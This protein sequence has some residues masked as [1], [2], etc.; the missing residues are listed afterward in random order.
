MEMTTR[1][2][3]VYHHLPHYRRAIFQEL[4]NDATLEVE[5]VAANQ[6]RDGSIPTIPTNELGSFH[7]VTNHWVGRFMWQSGLLGLLIRRRPDVVI[8]LGDASY[9]TTWLGSLLG[10]ALGSR[11]LFWTIGWHK[12]EAGVR[13]IVRILFYRLAHQLLL[14]GNVAR[15]IGLEMGYPATR[16][17]V[18]YNSSSAPSPLLAT[19]PESLDEFA[20]KLPSGDRPVA[21]AVIRLNRVKRLDMLVQAAS[22]LRSRGTDVD[23]L[24]VGEGPELAKLT[25]QARSL[26]VRLYTPG[27]AYGDAALARV[28][29]VTDVTVV[30]SV[31]GLTVLQSLRYGRPV[32]THDNIYDQAPESE[33]IT[34]GRTGDYYHYGDVES[35]AN[36]MEVWLT[37]RR[38]SREYTAAQCMASIQDRWSPHAQCRLIRA[39]IHAL[40]TEEN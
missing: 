33:A 32:I 25:D 15:G 37:H 8:F 2:M 40:H 16:M 22:L 19:D 7:P 35:L 17:S 5:F 38:A 24:L 1:V 13:R 6:S 31:A 30:P 28:Y 27:V 26:G 23:V 3:V 14:Y 18:I 34:P 20:T 39:E 11:V 21:T 10:R 12:P 29:G 9:V 36:V 4:E